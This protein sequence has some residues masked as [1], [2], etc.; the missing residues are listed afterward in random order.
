M[1]E[2]EKRILADKML[3]TIY[4]VNRA[5]ELGYINGGD[6]KLTPSGFDRAMDLIESGVRL[7]GETIKRFGWSDDISSLIL[8]LQDKLH[9]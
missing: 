5:Q 2:T 9:G 3:V 1:K 8:K 6:D 7:D 4:Y